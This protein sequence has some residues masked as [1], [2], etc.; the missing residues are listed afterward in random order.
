MWAVKGTLAVEGAPEPHVIS[1]GVLLSH[2]HPTILGIRTVPFLTAHT[3]LTDHPRGIC[4]TQEQ[5]SPVLPHFTRLAE[6]KLNFNMPCGLGGSLHHPMTFLQ[7]L[8]RAGSSIWAERYKSSLALQI[9]WRRGDRIRLELIPD[10]P[11]FWWRVHLGANEHASVLCFPRCKTRGVVRLPAGDLPVHGE[12]MLEQVLV[13][14]NPHR[15]CRNL[16]WL[17]V[18][19]PEH[20]RLFVY[21]LTDPRGLRVPTQAFLCHPDGR[22]QAIDDVDLQPLEVWR[23]LLDHRFYVTRWRLTVSQLKLQADLTAPVA[24]QEVPGALGLLPFYLGAMQARGDMDGTE[25][26]FSAYT[27]QQYR[28]TDQLLLWL[29]GK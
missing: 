21:A 7:S 14:R 2:V 27:M 17:M 8:V 3:S 26:S 6:D 10:T 1:I 12:M 25:F 28:D 16:T 29:A 9:P 13:P 22:L 19:L 11:P 23:S 4:Y 24:T 18:E 20:C 15:V 5:L